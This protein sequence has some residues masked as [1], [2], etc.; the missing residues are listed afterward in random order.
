MD[1]SL[2]SFD[3]EENL[4]K[5]LVFYGEELTDEFTIDKKLIN[6]FREWM[7]EDLNDNGENFDG[8]N[9]IDLTKYTDD[10]IMEMF[11]DSSTRLLEENG[12]DEGFRF[13]FF[14]FIYYCDSE[15]TNEAY[16][17]IEGEIERMNNPTQC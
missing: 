8:N 9:S 17:E 14:R 16:L 3:Y 6:A 4:E 11:A 5:L 2:T 13:A 12:F 10:E 7:G 15:L 1:R